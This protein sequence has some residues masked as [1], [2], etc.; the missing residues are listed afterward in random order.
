MRSR[1]TGRGSMLEVRL[2]GQFDV[3]L[4]GEPAEIPSRPAQSLLAYLMLNADKSHRRERLAGLLWPESEESNARGNLRH[5]LWRLGKSIGRD[6]FHTQSGSIAFNTQH[7]FTL[8]VAVLEQGP[9]DDSLEALIDVVSVYEGELLPGFYDD[10]IDLERERLKS[11]FEQRMQA[12]LERLV[13]ER[14]W[15]AV[16][17]WGER[18]IGHGQFTEQPYRAL[19]RAHWALGDRAN[20]AATYHRLRDSLEQEMDIEPSPQTQNLFEELLESELPAHLS[21]TEPE[22]SD[23]LGAGDVLSPFE[24]DFEEV[25]A[26][27]GLERSTPLVGRQQELA[28][29]EGYLERAIDGEGQVAFIM[30]DAGSGKT[31]LVESFASDAARSNPQLLTVFGACH[32]FPGLGDPYAPFREV[33]S[34]LTGDVHAR[35]Q[36]GSISRA[37][38]QRLHKIAP[39]TLRTMAESAPDLIQAFVPERVAKSALATTLS[40]SHAS[41]HGR[42]AA[43]P[44][45]RSMTTPHV[46]RLFEEYVEVLNQVASEQPLLIV[47]DDLHWIDPSSAGLLFHIARHLQ[48]LPIVI[49]GT[50]RPEEVRP[51]RD[52]SPHPLAGVLTELKRLFGDVW[53]DLEREGRGDGRQMVDALLDIDPNQLGDEFRE[54]LARVTAGHPLFTLELVKDLKDRGGIVRNEDGQWVETEDFSWQ[55]I[56]AKVEGVIERRIRELDQELKEALTVGSVQGNVFAVEVVAS[57]IGVDQA[58]LVRRLSR[59]A[60]RVHHIIFELGGDRGKRPHLTEFRFRHVLF[61]RYLYQSLGHGERSYLHREVGLGLERAYG[62]HVERIAAQ[63]AGHFQAADLAGKAVRYLHLAGEQALRVSAY[64]EAA[65]HLTAALEMFDQAREGGGPS[66]DGQ[67]AGADEHDKSRLLARLGEAKYYL[68]ALEESQTH[69]ERALELSGLDGVPQDRRGLWLGLVGQLVV[70][71]WHLLRPYRFGEKS[72]TSRPQYLEG[73][74]LLQ[75]LG[76]VYLFTKDP[77]WVTYAA[78]RSLNLAEGA[79]SSPELAKAYAGASVIAPQLRLHRLASRYYERAQEAAEAVDQP[80]VVAYV[81]LASSLYLTGTGRLRKSRRA[82][83]RANEL[84]DDQGD[85]NRLA[86]GLALL[87]A[88]HTLEGNFKAREHQVE[89]LRSLASR[90]GSIQHQVW[91]LHALGEN[92]LLAGEKADMPRA[93][94]HIQRGMALA[95]ETRGQAEE[96]FATGLLAVA[97]FR[98]GNFESALEVADEAVE[99]MD[100]APPAT[101]TALEGYSGVAETYIG[102]WRAGDGRADRDRIESNTGWVCEELQRQAKIFPVIEPRARLWSGMYRATEGDLKR[103]RSSVTQ[104]LEAARRLGM[105][106]DQA[107]AHYHLALLLGAEHNRRRAHLLRGKELFRKLSAA[108]W[109]AKTERE[110]TA[111]DEG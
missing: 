109:L 26:Q 78:L 30:G 101:Y 61:Q 99:R 38:A 105:P 73:A 52:G 8:D 20:L 12:L 58:A 96:A 102:L 84:L 29:L 2:L 13:A 97:H 74:S 37:Q 77:Y 49:V 95:E 21:Q 72:P 57:V 43:D 64:E 32:S 15:A 107:L 108:Y 25:H 48:N 106:F 41:P 53:I 18:W 93:I 70:Q 71:A 65:A 81:W 22:S 92:L 33:L 9:R 4:N 90:S 100:Q 36:T 94:E 76:E 86:I 11:V 19:M 62:E 59:E 56:P 54:K 83:E 55:H 67:S 39:E 63:L 5:A 10:W 14:R 103:G 91:A 7:P 40:G 98:D 45:W 51:L 88:V 85:W 104:S 35:M 31:A 34:M 17:E 3:R 44:A 24:Q 23:L 42:E 82:L 27:N 47:L 79:G 87:G 16:L 111:V 66:Q 1:R 60:E 80:N 6:Y 110:L 75:M 46:R 28:R 89:K 69:L 68:G 50:Y